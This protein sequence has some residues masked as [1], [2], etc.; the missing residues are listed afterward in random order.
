MGEI[1][2]ETYLDIIKIPEKY[3]DSKGVLGF[4]IENGIKLATDDGL[5]RQ[6][7]YLGRASRRD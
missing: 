7:F 4:N 6:S 5:D 3:L 2:S 1:L